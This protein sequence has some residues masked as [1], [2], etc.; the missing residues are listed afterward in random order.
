M[1]KTD[2]NKLTLE[3]IGSFLGKLAEKSESVYWLS[4]ADFKKIQ[5]IS[6]AYE[7]IWGRNRDIL[8]KEPELWITYLHPDDVVGH[9]PIHAMAERV[10]K[11]G[12]SARYHESYRIIRPDGEIRWIIDQGFPIYNVDGQCCGITGVAV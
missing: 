4:S 3:D 10:E 8:Y 1:G 7:K 12:P 2:N 11:E 5:Y 6:P 9:H